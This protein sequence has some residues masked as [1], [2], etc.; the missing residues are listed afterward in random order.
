MATKSN[1]QSKTD[2]TQETVDR[3]RELNERIVETARTAGTSYL[4]LYERTLN[5]IASYQES[6]A[7]A[8]PV[9]WL[10]RVIEAQAAFTRELG[11]LAAATA[12]EALKQ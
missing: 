9:D 12:R 11:N 2:A 6:L 4:D 7:S 5:T 8:T 10:Q 3:I 1:A